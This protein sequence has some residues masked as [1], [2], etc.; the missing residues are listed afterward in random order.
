MTWRSL[1]ASITSNI[2]DFNIYHDPSLHFAADMP[3]SPH[4]SSRARIS[5]DPT[6]SSPAPTHLGQ[7]SG[8]FND[9]ATRVLLGLNADAVPLNSGTYGEEELGVKPVKISLLRQK[10]HDHLLL[11]FTPRNPWFHYAQISMY[12]KK[13]QYAIHLEARRELDRHLSKSLLDAQISSN[14][15]GIFLPEY[16]R[17]LVPKLRYKV[18]G[19]EE[20]FFYQFQIFFSPSAHRIRAV[21]IG[22]VCAILDA[23]SNLAQVL[24]GDPGE[25]E[26][27]SPVGIIVDSE[28]LSEEERTLVN[29]YRS[30]DLPVEGT[31][32]EGMPSLVTADQARLIL[33]GKAKGKEVSTE[34]PDDITL[35]DD[36]DDA[37]DY[38]RIQPDHAAQGLNADGRR[39]TNAETR[40]EEDDAFVLDYT[41]E[42]EE[43]AA[44][45]DQATAMEV[46]PAPPY[47][48]P[49]PG[50]NEPFGTSALQVS[51]GET[52]GSTGT[53]QQSL[54]PVSAVTSIHSS[55]G[56]SANSSASASGALPTGYRQHRRSPVAARRSNDWRGRSSLSGPRTRSPRYRSPSPRRAS[57]PRNRSPSGRYQHSPPRPQESVRRYSPRRYSPRRRSPSPNPYSRRR[58]P[59][60]SSAMAVY[61]QGMLAGLPPGACKR[62]YS[63]RSS[64]GLNKL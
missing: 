2:G 38:A 49:A 54:T 18:G 42:R 29:A 5:C 52:G 62:D 60:R 39:Q 35:D 17:N 21:R 8:Y 37:L 63:Y 4:E 20:P 19:D 1:S 27:G 58:S 56:A 33:F 47:S 55:E 45:R 50:E 25:W 24:Q 46:D 43:A 26:K 51:L 44:A 6:E 31:L 11:P 61:T 30:L 14:E 16:A 28:E 10:L 7:P 22:R 40:E 41:A 15:T 34:L 53:P 12:E 32:P 9:E 64:G 48:P 13:R 3:L 59:P 57:P 23:L 36:D